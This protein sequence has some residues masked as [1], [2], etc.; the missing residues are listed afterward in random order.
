MD[1]TALLDALRGHYTSWFVVFSALTAFEVLNPREDHSLRSRLLGAG[2]WIVSLLIS[3]SSFVLL[4]I[5]V[6]HFGITPLLAVPG[7]DRLPGGVIIGVALAAVIG[8]VVNDFFF[9]WFHRFQHRYLWRWHAVH[10]SIE[11]LSAVN[12]YHH[13]AE[14]LISLVVMQIPMSLLVGIATPASA[15]A[16]TILYLH[17]VWIHSP[18]RITLGPL[19]AFIVDNRFHRIHH[20]VEPQHFDKNFGAFTTLWDRLFGTCHMPARDEWPVVGISAARQPRSFGEWV[21]LPWRMNSG[22]APKPDTQ[23][24]PRISAPTS[25]AWIDTVSAGISSTDRAATHR[26]P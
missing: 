18:T 19:R 24:S 21:T 23:P 15:I 12:S 1:A 5:L 14:A 8:A 17:I 4:A 9:Y 3:F 11:R 16:T 13:P 7:A 26:A 2:F 25:P 10:H 20:S 6:Q 22:D